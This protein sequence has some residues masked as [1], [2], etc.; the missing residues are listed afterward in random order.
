MIFTLFG[1][2]AP[3]FLCALSGF[4]WGKKKKPF[5]N[6]LIALLIMDIGAPALIIS[7]LTTI[8][9]N[10]SELLNFSVYTFSILLVTSLINYLM[11]LLFKKDI[12]TFLVAT[13]FGN[14]ANMGLPLCLFAFG[15]KGLA[16]ALIYYALVSFFHFTA[17][18]ALMSGSL[19]LSQLLKKPIILATIFSCLMLA[20]ETSLPQWLNNTLSLLGQMTIPLMLITLGVSL[21]RL[22]IVNLSES[23][24]LSSMRVI[25]GLAIA[26]LLTKALALEGITRG[27]LILQSGMPLAIF[28]YLL[29]ER[30][31]R[32]PEKI[33]GMVVTS[34]LMSLILLPFILQLIL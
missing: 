15:E 16:L 22:K 4:I 1:I 23:L 12:R 31:K 34:T 32:D 27:V 28:N 19:Q 33:A 17:G 3:T 8:S 7:T 26:F 14:H 18:I 24:L 10:K 29:A 21:S 11:L 2:I 30:Y 6:N 9:L 13:V 5:D 20:T 25:T